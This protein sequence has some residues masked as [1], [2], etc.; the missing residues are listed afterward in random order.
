MTQSK[1]NYRFYAKIWIGVGWKRLRIGAL[2]AISK[3]DAQSQV[4]VPNGGATRS[5]SWG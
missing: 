1:R 5:H 3:I 2:F 4:K